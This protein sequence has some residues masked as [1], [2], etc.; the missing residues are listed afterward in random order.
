[1]DNEH[2]KVIRIIDNPNPYDVIAHNRPLF[3]IG[4]IDDQPISRVV[5]DGSSIVNILTAKT[6]S[7]LRI[8]P[9]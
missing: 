8:E 4:R 1:M 2:N 9:S 3:I 7:Y 6:F 5:I